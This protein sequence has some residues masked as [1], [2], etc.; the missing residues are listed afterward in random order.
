MTNKLL[1]PSLPEAQRFLD[2]LEQAG[3]FTFQTFDDRK[4][5]GNRNLVRIIHGDLSNHTRLLQEMNQAGSGVF[6][7]V[8]RTDLKGRK[9]ENVIATRAVFV[10]L[11]GAPLEPV[12][13]FELEPQIVVE[14]SP[15]RWH[16]YWLCDVALTDFGA[17]QAAII[18]KFTGD[19]NVKDLPRVMR[20]PGFYHQKHQDKMPFMTRIESIMEG[21][22]LA[23]Y[24]TQEIL[25]AF[26]IP[27]VKKASKSAP[28]DERDT[29]RYVAKNDNR[30]V[31]TLSNLDPEDREE[32]IAVAHGLKSDGEDN[33]ELFLTWSR[34]ELTGC[35]PNN[36]VSD[37]DVIKTWKS[38]D[39]TRTDIGA[40]FSRARSKDCISQLAKSEVSDLQSNSHVACAR[41][42]ITQHSTSRNPLIFDEGEFW[43]YNT[44]FWGKV[45][46]NVLRV[47]VHDLDGKNYGN[48]KR[49]IQASKSFID[50]VISEMAASITME[51]FFNDSPVG[52]NLD[53]G[54]VSLAEDGTLKLEKHSPKHKQ[55]A[56]IN[57]E[58]QPEIPTELYGYT[59]ILFEGCFGQEDQALRRLMLQ[60]I[61][62]ALLGISTTIHSPKGFVFFGATASNGKSTILRVIRQLLP[63]YA[64]CSI[65]PADFDKEQSL[66]TLVGCMANLSD[67]LSSSKSIASDKMKAVITGDVV[68]AKVIYKEVFNFAPKA[69]HVFATNALPT[70]KGGVDAG[71][72]RRMLVVPFDRTIPQEDRIVDIAQK[73]IAEEASLLVC[74]SLLAGAHVYKNGQFSI[75][76]NCIDATELWFKEADPVRE[77]YEEGG[78]TK[79]AAKKPVLLKDL[80]KKFA[81]DMED[82]CDVGFT[83]QKRRF[84]AQ[85]RALIARDPEWQISRRSD[86]DT[87]SAAKL[88]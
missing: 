88:V 28:S 40:L 39:P 9:A 1:K 4:G 85:I 6:V 65:P 50:G 44:K 14:S 36:Y 31:E 61:G 80:Y 83:P 5:L 79:H 70:F 48:G 12:L 27:E 53:N 10:D 57:C 42:L 67:E 77:W 3:K 49:S 26:P 24:T 7:T 66:A 33:L 59:N 78:L 63:D 72:E 55:R 73:I 69:I 17:I 68:S 11:D 29:P 38:V 22:Q 58:W 15:G 74:A 21:E 64:T 87:V 37:E 56:C 16:A 35:T 86:G 52:A 8:N 51:A 84:F 71:V 30:L 75:P 60:V 18:E 45:A 54:F 19:K 23:P 32:W 25:E 76:H 46:R 43:H 82:T 81:G 34:G 13:N 2:A 41:Y 20:L 47:W 62:T